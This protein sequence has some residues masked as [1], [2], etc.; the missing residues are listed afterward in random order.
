M[1]EGYETEQA[2]LINEIIGL[3]DWVGT[4]EDANNSVDA[5]LALVKKYVDILVVHPARNQTWP[6]RYNLPL[7]VLSSLAGGSPPVFSTLAGTNFSPSASSLTPRMH[8]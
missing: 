3:E 7:P 2:A 8:H 5:F 1:S 4:R 6:L